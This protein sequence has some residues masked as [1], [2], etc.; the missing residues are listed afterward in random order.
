MKKYN[1]FTGI[2]ILCM[3]LFLLTS[4]AFAEEAGGKEITRYLQGSRFTKDDFPQK[5]KHN[6]LPREKVEDISLIYDENKYEIMYFTENLQQRTDDLDEVVYIALFASECEGAMGAAYEWVGKINI[7][8]EEKGLLTVKIKAEGEEDQPEPDAQP[9]L[10]PEE[11]AVQAAPTEME[12]ADDNP[13]EMPAATESV[14]KEINIVIE[15]ERAVLRSDAAYLYAA[16]R[17]ENA[18]I[19]NPKEIY[20]S[21]DYEGKSKNIKNEEL[22][23]TPGDGGVYFLKA[24]GKAN[25]GDTIKIKVIYEDFES[26]EKEL[27]VE[28]AKVELKEILIW[29]ICPKL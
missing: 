3:V 20:A 4:A 15:E 9:T 19:I 7:F 27:T 14:A 13:K 25:L 11:T 8:A 6:I 10:Q 26:E 23:I 18:E 29:M 28:A 22:N 24:T 17:I 1:L 2:M 21:I 16:V 5:C 12:T